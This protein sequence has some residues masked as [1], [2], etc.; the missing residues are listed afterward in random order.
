[1]DMKTAACILALAQMAAQPVAV[2]RVLPLQDGSAAATTPSSA[3]PPCEIAGS[4]EL[5]LTCAYAAASS[6]SADSRAVP[7]ISLNRAV[8]SFDPTD[9]SRMH[10]AL[11]FTN[12]SGSAIAEKR[13]VYIAIDDEKGDNHLRRPLPHVDFTKL[14][15]RKLTECQETLVA[16]AFAPGP[17]VVSL[18][19][20][21]NDPA[22]KFDPTHNF[23]LSSAG[24]VNGATGLNL[25]AKITIAKPPPRRSRAKPD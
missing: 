21:S 10:I 16:P 2:S 9:E 22:T 13:T 11:S 18:W 23:L 15:P 25:V 3:A 20:P 19:I 14:D 24:M 4:R 1:M 12:E 7:R 8:I 5:T 17:Y 6:D